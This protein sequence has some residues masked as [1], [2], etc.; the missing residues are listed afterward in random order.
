MKENKLVPYTNPLYK[1]LANKCVKTLS[2]QKKEDR[3]H[4]VFITQRDFKTLQKATEQI[5]VD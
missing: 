4:L 3:T 5:T 2:F 1:P